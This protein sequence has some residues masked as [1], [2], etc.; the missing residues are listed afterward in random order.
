MAT[1]RAVRGTT[2]ARRNKRVAT[3]LAVALREQ[4]QHAT[5]TRLL[6]I[7][8]FGFRVEVDGLAVDS[9]VWLRLPEAEPIM[10]RVVWSDHKATGCLF[11]DM[12]DMELF[13]RTIRSGDTAATVITGPWKPAAA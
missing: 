4:G 2:E 3:D 9:I 1:A 7:S 13:R 11:T 8:R 12:L 6:D 10:A 5:S